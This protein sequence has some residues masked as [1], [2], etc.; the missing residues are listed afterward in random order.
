MNIMHHLIAFLRHLIRRYI[1]DGCRE[2]AAALTY[3]SLFA[4]VP[5]MTVSY[6]VLSAVPEFQSVGNDIQ[7]MIFSHFIPST[8]A[9]IQ[10]YLVQFSQQA[11]KLSTV[12]AAFLAVTA[13]LMLKSIE[14]TFN[15]I[16]RTQQNRKGLSNFLLYWAVL[17]LG[18]IFIGIGL[19]VTTYLLSLSIF[20]TEDVALITPLF[21][22]FLPL[23]LVTA[24]F[25]LLFAAV[26][27]CHVPFK[28]ALIGGAITAICLELS[29]QLFT[30]LVANTSYQVIYGTFAAIPLFLV[31]VYFSWLIVLM[32]AEFVRALSS[33]HALKSS[34]YP[35]LILTIGLIDAMA[36]QQNNNQPPFHD[37][38]ITSQP[39]LFDNDS[40]SAHHWQALRTTLLEQKIIYQTNDD[41]YVLGINIHLIDIWSLAKRLPGGL[42]LE[43][44]SSITAIEKDS[45]PWLA[46]LKQAIVNIN[47]HN[48]QQLDSSLSALISEK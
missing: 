7:S 27:N 43:E 37:E 12:G 33:F 45:C 18:P 2:S 26:P 13:Y 8:G 35:N 10:Q 3:T 21:L 32:G 48:Q 20:E 30:T 47:Q 15:K 34:D 16:W 38:D 28:H 9:E 46:K 17:S 1:E 29:K 6:A 4:V 24:T 41:A 36:K 19:L 31:W 42:D 23:L 44:L 22:Q 25:T 5:L 14:T 39:W 11:Q 40:I